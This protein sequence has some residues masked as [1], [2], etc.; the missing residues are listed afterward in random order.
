M[1]AII[2]VTITG[3]ALVVTVVVWSLDPRAN[4]HSEIRE[5]SRPF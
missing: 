5:G 3:L 4:K 2:I 1:I